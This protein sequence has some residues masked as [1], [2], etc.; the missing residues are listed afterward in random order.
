M[1]PNNRPKK[2]LNKARGLAGMGMGVFYLFVAVWVV[3]MENVGQFN[4]GKTFSY[5]VG[6]LM[7]FYGIFRIYRGQRIYKTKD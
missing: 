1:T 7:T 2:S 3:Y 6:A 5:L 4:I